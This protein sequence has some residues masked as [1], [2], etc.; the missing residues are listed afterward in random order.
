MGS[1]AGVGEQHLDRWGITHKKTRTHIHRV[2][3]LFH[4]WDRQPDA[5][6]FLCRAFSYYDRLI[7]HPRHGT[8]DFGFNSKQSVDSSK[9][10]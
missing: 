7:Q 9:A 3:E 8:N 5:I 10:Q 6:A 4:S 2:A 1:S